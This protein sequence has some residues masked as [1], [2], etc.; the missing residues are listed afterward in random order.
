MKTIPKFLK[1]YFWDT[2]FRKLNKKDHSYFIVERILEHG[3]E[4]AIKWMRH[5]FGLAEIRAVLTSSRNLSSRSANFWQL[6]LNV[7]KNEILCL[8]K[9]FREKQKAT[10]KY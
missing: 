9:S 3:D 10:W 5:N 4:K 7:N 1:K 8:K 6:I 2:D